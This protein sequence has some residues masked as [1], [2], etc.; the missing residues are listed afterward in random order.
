M[1]PSA[2]EKWNETLMDTDGHNSKAASPTLQ[3]PASSEVSEVNKEQDTCVICLSTVSNKHVLSKCK[4]KFCRPCIQ[5]AFSYKPVCPVCQTSYG[6]QKGNQ[7]DGRMSV[8]VVRESLPGYERCGTIVITYNIEGGIQTVSVSEFHGFLSSKL[9]LSEPQGLF[10][11]QLAV[12]F[13]VI[14]MVI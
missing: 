3:H 1:S 7:P 11:Y 9:R 14:S 8:V 13:P 10:Y 6:V 12:D 2:T 4:H 5:E